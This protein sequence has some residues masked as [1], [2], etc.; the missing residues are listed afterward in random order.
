MYTYNTQRKK[1]SNSKKE[2]DR[3]MRSL[4]IPIRYH[5]RNPLLARLPVKSLVQCFGHDPH[6][7]KYKVVRVNNTCFSPGSSE[8][9]YD[10]DHCDVDV[11]TLGTKKWRRIETPCCLA[12]SRSVPYLNGA[13]HWFR[14]TDQSRWEVWRQR[15]L[16][17]ITLHLL[18][19]G[20]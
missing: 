19:T 6:S 4:N 5:Y 13:L 8:A 2:R 1:K 12:H 17:Q 11:Y 18:S 15:V 20:A 10:I 14:L 3:H 9:G 7:N 16:D